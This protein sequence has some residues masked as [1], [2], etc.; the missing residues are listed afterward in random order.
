[1]DTIT[2]NGKIVSRSQNLRGILDYARKFP[3]ESAYVRRMPEGKARVK[4]VFSNR[5]ISVTQ[6][7]SYIIAIQWIKSRRSWG[8]VPQLDML[9]MFD[10]DLYDADM[11]DLSP[12]D[13]RAIVSRPGKFDQES[14]YIPYMWD[15]LLNWGDSPD[16]EATDKYWDSIGYVDDSETLASD[17]CAPY[18]Y[19]YDCDLIDYLLFPELL[20]N[21]YNRSVMVSVWLYED[22]QGFVNVY[23]TKELGFNIGKLW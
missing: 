5:A 9:T 1:M 12:S 8:I 22:D 11:G 17:Y 15:N 20:G 18:V 10:P 4:I 2:L 21:Y 7:E 13:Y 14:A 6:W 16:Y 19:R 3:V 23:D